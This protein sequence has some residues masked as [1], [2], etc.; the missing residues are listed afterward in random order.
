MPNKHRT[1][2]LIVIDNI[3]TAATC[4]T[5]CEMDALLNIYN[6]HNDKINCIIFNLE[7]VNSTQLH[8]PRFL[9]E[10]RRFQLH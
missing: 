6:N 4:N 7:R 9:I 8:D 2:D 1:R 5:I 3:L 10:T